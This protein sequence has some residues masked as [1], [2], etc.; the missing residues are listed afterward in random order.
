MCYLK[1]KW[2]SKQWLQGNFSHTATH[3]TVLELDTNIDTNVAAT[4]SINVKNEN[5]SCTW[6]NFI[7]VITESVNLFLSGNDIIYYIWYYKCLQIIVTQEHF[8]DLLHC[9]IMPN[10]LHYLSQN[11]TLQLLQHVLLHF[12]FII[13]LSIFIGSPIQWYFSTH[14]R[15]TLLLL[16]TATILWHHCDTMVP[17]SLTYSQYWSVWVQIKSSS[18]L[19]YYRI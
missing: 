4:L 14:S 12:H 18:T 1:R 13:L 6:S 8:K 2:L 16:L 9:L 10:V 19:V 7:V 3:F 11:Y 5:N 15:H 17:S